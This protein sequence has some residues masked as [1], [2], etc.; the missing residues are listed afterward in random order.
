MSDAPPAMNDEELRTL[1][2]AALDDQTEVVRAELWDE[3]RVRAKRRG[4]W[5]TTNTLTEESCRGLAAYL[6]G[7]LDLAEFPDL[8][9]AFV[10]PSSAVLGDAQGGDECAVRLHLGAIPEVGPLAVLTIAPAEV[11]SA[12]MLIVDEDLAGAWEAAMST[13]LE[14]LE[15]EDIEGCFAGLDE[16]VAAAEGMGPAGHMALAISLSHVGHLRLEEN[17]PD[18]ARAALE[19]A[20]ALEIEGEAPDT[21]AERLHLLAMTCARMTEPAEAITAL[22]HAVAL[23]EEAFGPEDLGLHPLL[24][25]LASLAQDGGDP[26]ASRAAL[27]R[28]QSIRESVLEA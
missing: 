20:V 6:L 16:A 25:D 22:H 27:A 9:S 15:E 11:L 1:L 17:R 26:A 23:L 14:R 13:A 5:S 21:L 18:L 24:V 2:A 19:R 8:P 28:W 12:P 4:D 7:V 3:G 10:L